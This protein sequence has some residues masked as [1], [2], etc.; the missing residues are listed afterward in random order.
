MT[1]RAR[2]IVRGNEIPLPAHIDMRG[3]LQFLILWEI[4]AQPLHGREIA[5][6]I[7][8]RRGDP[9]NPGTIYPALHELA[10]EG[11]VEARGEGRR[12]AYLLTDLGREELAAAHGFF[13]AA[14]GDIVA[15]GS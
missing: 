3:M 10:R 13:K 7:G 6:R 14:Y 9:P 15:S 11:L 4:R 2:A 1:K 12:V 8:T 5:R